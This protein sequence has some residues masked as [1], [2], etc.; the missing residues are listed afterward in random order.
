MTLSEAKR[1]VK[2][3]TVIQAVGHYNAKASGPRT[4]TKVQTN[5]FW[6]ANEL[7]E[8]GW[9]AWP[10]AKRTRSVGDDAICLLCDDGAPMS[11]F[12]IPSETDRG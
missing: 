7:I 5:G 3:G 6:F 4:V 8:R 11:T 2:V 1:R 12:V 9:C 10:P